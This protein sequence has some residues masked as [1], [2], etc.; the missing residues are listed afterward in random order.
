MYVIFSSLSR[1][2]NDFLH[3]GFIHNI[4]VLIRKY[5]LV[6]ALLAMVSKNYFKM[7]RVFIKV[8]R[9]HMYVRQVGLCIFVFIYNIMVFLARSCGK[10]HQI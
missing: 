5:W 3:A 9:M 8:Y 10:L 6:P 1:I 2:D 7:M 4:L